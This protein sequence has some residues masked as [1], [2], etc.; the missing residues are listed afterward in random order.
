[1]TTQL[2][3][4]DAPAWSQ[5][6]RDFDG[7]YKSFVDNRNALLQLGPYIQSKHPELLPQYQSLL[8]RSNALAPKLQALAE[9][10]QKVG[11]WLGTLG[12]VYQSAV[13]ATSRAIEKAAGLVSS[14]RRALGLGE[15][16]IAPVVVIV[17]VAA[18]AATLAGITK[19]V[20]DAFL[21]AK[22]LNA[23]QELEQRGYTVDAAAAA[24][25]QVMG[26]P[27]APGGLERTVSSILWVVVL[28]VIGVPIVSKLL[29]SSSSR[30]G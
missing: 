7:A 12:T 11:G 2:V 27:D 21:F 10:R 3:A 15:L 16:G 26:K 8:Q 6:V 13:D 28:A 17:G 24:V 29:S 9:T 1:M 4:K 20:S 18:A 30:E 5:F 14:A 23:L 19:W 22:R 25:N